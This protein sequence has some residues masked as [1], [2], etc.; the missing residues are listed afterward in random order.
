MRAFLLLSLTLCVRL[1]I[2]LSIAHSLSS[3]VSLCEVLRLIV[4]SFCR[5][6]C[7]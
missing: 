7:L 4:F 5:K 6:S 2:A 1:Y 3:L